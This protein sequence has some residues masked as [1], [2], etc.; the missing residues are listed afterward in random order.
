M[1]AGAGFHAD[2][3]G[4]LALKE[5]QHLVTPKLAAQ[6]NTPFRVYAV[7]MENRL[8]KI[9]PDCGNIV[10]GWLPLLVMFTAPN[11]AHC[12]A[13]SA[14]HPLHQWRINGELLEPHLQGFPRA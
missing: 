13:G 2:Q 10:H 12:D 14:S 3:A 7:Q 6:Q 5:L 1:R 9:D 4:W 11:M 8:R